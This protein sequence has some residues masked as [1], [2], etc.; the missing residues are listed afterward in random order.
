MV[1]LPPDNVAAGRHKFLAAHVTAALCTSPLL[2]ALLVAATS[3]AAA[4]VASAASTSPALAAS[5]SALRCTSA[6][7]VTSG[8]FQNALASPEILNKMA[9]LIRFNQQ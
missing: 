4:R 8:Q 1:H 2:P 6:A 7:S 5:F 9:F 3:A